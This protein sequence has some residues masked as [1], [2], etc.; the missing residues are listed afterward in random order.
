[1]SLPKGVIIMVW[2]S[3][4][5]AELDEK[6]NIT[7]PIEYTIVPDNEADTANGR[8][9]ESLP[10]SQALLGHL[11]GDTVETTIDDRPVRL[12]VVSIAHG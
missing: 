5:L 10:A 1:M 9:G 2:S 3:L 7:R 12:R 6:D 8:F 11:T 4:V